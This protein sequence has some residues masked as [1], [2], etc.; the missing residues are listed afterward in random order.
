VTY[1]IAR[2]SLLFWISIGNV[3]PIY[4]IH[5]RETGLGRTCHLDQFG[6]TIAKTLP[7]ILLAVCKACRDNDNEQDLKSNLFISPRNLREQVERSNTS[8]RPAS[9]TANACAGS[10]AGVSRTSQARSSERA[11]QC[12]HAAAIRLCWSS[13]LPRSNE[14][15]KL[16]D[17]VRRAGCFSLDAAKPSSMRNRCGCQ[18]VQF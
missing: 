12:V 7:G 2:E 15:Q 9:T 18:N 3:N 11:D 8:T 17:R 5:S 14:K 10:S 6:T 1:G 13:T 4:W 16:G